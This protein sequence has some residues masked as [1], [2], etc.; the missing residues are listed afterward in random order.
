MSEVIKA[1]KVAGIRMVGLQRGRWDLNEASGI[2]TPTDGRCEQPMS[3]GA[4]KSVRESCSR[5]L[6]IA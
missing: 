3:P 4:R 1:A 6:F 2:L 5:T